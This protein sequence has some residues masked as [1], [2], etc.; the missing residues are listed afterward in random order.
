[1]APK[2][3]AAKKATKKKTV[4]TKTP[5]KKATK[6]KARRTP[7]QVA[8]D[9][10]G[11]QRSLLGYIYQ[12]FGSADEIVAFANLSEEYLKCEERLVLETFGQDSFVARNTSTQRAKFTQYKH[13]ETGLAQ[14]VLIRTVLE[15]LLSSVDA[16]NLEIGDCDFVLRMNHGLS[17]QCE[18]LVKS[19]REKDRDLIDQALWGRKNVERHPRAKEILDVACLFTI[20]DNVPMSDFEATLNSRFNELGITEEEQPD[21]VTHVLGRFLTVLKTGGWS[22]VSLSNFDDWATKIN[23]STTLRGTVSREKQIEKIRF[24]IEDIAGF[25]RVIPRSN[26]SSILQA[27]VTNPLTVVH[28]KGGRGKSLGTY[29]TLFEAAQTFDQI[30]FVATERYL[31]LKEISLI[32]QIWGVST[33]GTESVNKECVFLG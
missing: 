16:A 22:E 24:G 33:N 14:P 25:D 18:S 11:G 8:A 26:H 30:E 21:A 17:P 3:R 28:G 32:N 2:K 4:K 10:R 6:K 1:M 19:I 12:L 9:L 5:R 13:T 23:S 29:R 7:N 31:V 20:E 27:I 15:K